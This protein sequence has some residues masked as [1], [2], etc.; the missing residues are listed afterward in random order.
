MIHVDKEMSI[1]EKGNVKKKKN[2]DN[3]K[4]KRNF[5]KER[6][7]NSQTQMRDDQHPLPSGKCRLKQGT[8]TEMAVIKKA[9]NTIYW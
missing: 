2:S 5:Q 4:N 1:K 7:K 8:N 3:F 6:E 9:D